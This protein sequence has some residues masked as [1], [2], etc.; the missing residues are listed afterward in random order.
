MTSPI[1]RDPLTGRFVTSKS[2]KE[3]PVVRLAYTVIYASC[4][5][6]LA[7]IISLLFFFLET[8]QLKIEII[9][10]REIIQEL[11]KEKSAPVI[12]SESEYKDS[13]APLTDELKG[14]PEPK[15]NPVSDKEKPQRKVRVF[16]GSEVMEYEP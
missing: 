12:V 2:K 15:T 16:R 1:L 4:Y 5:C 6:M 9:G 7:L 3:E 11:K 8:R 14:G 13:C 10:N